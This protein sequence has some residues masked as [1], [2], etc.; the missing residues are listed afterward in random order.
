MDDVENFLA[1]YG[2]MGMKWGKHSRPAGVSRGTN[3]VAKK[4]AQEFARAKMYYGQGAG[5]RRKLIRETV[6]ARKKRDPDYAKAFD[7]HF[8][9]QDLSTH[10]SKAVKQR[11]RTDRANTTKKT[12]KA[13]A[14]RLTGEMGNAAAM[15]G[16]AGA[17][18]AFYKSP[19]G[20]QMAKKS[21]TQIKDMVTQQRMKIAARQIKKYF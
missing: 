10:A 20:Q 15:V 12:G 4:D 17:G 2:K 5:T 21:V 13:I 18:Y 6:N 9:S 8:T 1:H 19:K 3:R 16:V 7:S 11:K 14:R